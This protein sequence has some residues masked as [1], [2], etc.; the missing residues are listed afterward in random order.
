LQ[1]T[2]FALVF[3]YLQ[4]LHRSVKDGCLPLTA[5]VLWAQHMQ[6]SRPAGTSLDMKKSSHKKLSAFLKVIAL[7]VA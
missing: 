1:F 2:F 3:V 7:A 5:S 6:P 4:A